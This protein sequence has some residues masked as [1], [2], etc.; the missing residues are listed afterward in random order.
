MDTFFPY[1][2][3]VYRQELLADLLPLSALPEVPQLVSFLEQLD[4][5]S[6][7]AVPAH[8]L[9]REFIGDSAYH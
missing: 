1:E 5:L 6:P 7:E 3:S 2:L 9:I 8:A 4:P